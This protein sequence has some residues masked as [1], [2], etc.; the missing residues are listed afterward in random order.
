MGSA[1]RKNG[2]EDLTTEDPIF[3]KIAFDATDLAIRWKFLRHIE[4]CRKF[5]ATFSRLAR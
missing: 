2:I 1:D 4:R 3:A 5:T